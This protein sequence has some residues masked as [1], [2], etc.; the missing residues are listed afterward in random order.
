MKN[1][2]EHNRRSVP[3]TMEL[4]RR[5]TDCNVV[6][7]LR[8]RVPGE[9]REYTLAGIR[10]FLDDRGY[11][12]LKELLAA[13][14]GRY[15]TG[16]YE[17]FS[18]WLGH[19][20][21]QDKATASVN[22]STA[23]LKRCVGE[24]EIIAFDRFV[25]ADEER[26]IL[27]VKLE[28]R[29]GDLVYS[30]TTV[31]LSGRSVKIVLQR[32]FQLQPMQP[33][34]VDFFELFE[35]Y[36]KPLLNRVPCR[37]T[38]ISH[39]HNQT[40][41]VVEPD[42]SAG[43]FRDWLV[44]R[45]EQAKQNTRHNVNPNDKIYN[46]VLAHYIR[47][48]CGSLHK[49]V[50]FLGRA[51]VDSAFLTPTAF[52]SLSCID[53]SGAVKTLCFDA[54]AQFVKKDREASSA[55]YFTWL[56]GELYGLSSRDIGRCAIENILAWL[57]RK[58]NWRV[59]LVSSVPLHNP[60]NDETAA[61]HRQADQRIAD[62]AGDLNRR[63]AELTAACQV[64]DIS[65]IFD[66]I[67]WT[68]TP[69]ADLSGIAETIAPVSQDYAVTVGDCERREPRFRVDGRVA[70]K[71]AHAVSNADL[72]DFST[73][74]LKLAPV[75][76]LPLACGVRINV[77]LSAWELRADI[78]P[79]GVDY[80]VANIGRES[81]RRIVGLKRDKVSTPRKTEVWFID[82]FKAL[83]ADADPC[84]ADLRQDYYFAL[85]SASITKNVAGLPFFIGRDDQGLRIVQAVGATALNAGPREFF[86][87]ARGEYEWEPLQLLVSDLSKAVADLAPMPGEHAPRLA[88]GIYCFRDESGEWHA[89]T[90]LHF[91]SA[92]AKREFIVQALTTE[93]F[94]FYHCALTGLNTLNDGR[95]ARIVEDTAVVS[96]KKA[97][98]VRALFNSLLAV[99][100]L[101]NITKLLAHIY[102]KLI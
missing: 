39:T 13:N 51:G 25:R 43:A 55:L 93:K 17:D 98:E 16:V 69:P 83:K 38:Q 36:E 10:H 74:G 22:F 47:L 41:I 99:G 6:V 24:P 61:L 45:L 63:F 73:L 33:V 71:A 82:R 79:G 60:E 28:V 78:D 81:G 14:S 57:C 95:I 56:D 86:R 9:C 92:R 19:M 102:R 15:T 66:R 75:E 37:I 80:T 77:D 50:I 20:L 68:T 1:T 62:D 11:V 101:T 44:D 100:E 52:G 30:G 91:E 23:L 31:D 21:E 26:L 53:A 29:A 97:K 88:T 90:D 7:D 3:D 27:A 42:D 35:R 48:Y 2:I 67:D 96:L 59:Y 58:P 89:Q 64:L 32:A 5:D 94:H 49:A 65:R 4:A 46:R 72:L 8:K 34:T 12:L 70:V 40:Q 18:E 84:L 54:F 85:A 76:D 87:N